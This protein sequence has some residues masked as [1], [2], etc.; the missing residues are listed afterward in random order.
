M[1]ELHQRKL[2]ELEYLFPLARPLDGLLPKVESPHRSILLSEVYKSQ[3]Q[4]LKNLSIHNFNIIDVR[5]SLE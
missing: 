4:Y 5:F 1:S 2:R 3:I